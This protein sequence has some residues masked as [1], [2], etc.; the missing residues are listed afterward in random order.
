M[1]SNTFDD[2]SH[3]ESNVLTFSICHVIIRPKVISL[4]GW[5]LFHRS[6]KVSFLKLWHISIE[7]CYCEVRQLLKSERGN[8]FLKSYYK[9]RQK[10][11]T[12]CVLQSASGIARHDRLLIQSQVVITK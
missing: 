6:H 2:C 1:Y 9:V 11:I 12:K 5:V 4:V 8:S 7:N 3:R 10:C